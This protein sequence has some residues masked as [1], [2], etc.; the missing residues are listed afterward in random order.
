MLIVLMSGVLM[1]FP[2]LNCARLL[3]LSGTVIRVVAI[4]TLLCFKNAGPLH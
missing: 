2:K 3:I 1:F 4:Y